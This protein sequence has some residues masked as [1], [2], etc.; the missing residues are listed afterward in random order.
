LK[1]YLSGESHG[2]GHEQARVCDSGCH[3]AEFGGFD[4][5]AQVVDFLFEARLVFR[6]GFVS[7]R[8]LPLVR[9]EFPMQETG[10]NGMKELR[11]ISCMCNLLVLTEAARSIF[12]PPSCVCFELVDGAPRVGKE[13][14]EDLSR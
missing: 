11:E 2:S 8:R 1:T 5:G 10:M 13:G 12:C 9:K 7:V 14:H 4:E 3:H 6:L